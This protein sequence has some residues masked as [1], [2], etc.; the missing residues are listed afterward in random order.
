MWRSGRGGLGGMW[1]S[2][3]G[4]RH[5]TTDTAREAHL[6]H[7]TLHDRLTRT[8]EPTAPTWTDPQTVLAPSL[9]L[10]ARRHVA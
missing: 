2:G 1:R 5:Y 6:N 9:A 3:R 10:R 8:S 7:H 4:G